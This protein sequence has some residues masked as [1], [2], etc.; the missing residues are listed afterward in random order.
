M[1]ERHWILEEP[2]GPGLVNPALLKNW[3]PWLSGFGKEGSFELR[4]KLVQKARKNMRRRTKGVSGSPC[5]GPEKTVLIGPVEK[6]V[7]KTF[8][9]GLV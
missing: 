2:G 9:E 4:D 6:K 7:E 5:E 1:G 8:S 3:R